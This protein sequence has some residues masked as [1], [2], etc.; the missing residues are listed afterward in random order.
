MINFSFF[1]HLK[2]KKITA[3]AG[4]R[5]RKSLVVVVHKMLQREI[6]DGEISLGET[7]SCFVMHFW[8]DQCYYQSLKTDP[9]A[10]R[11]AVMSLAPDS[12]FSRYFADVCSAV[13]TP[14]VGLWSSFLF[15]LNPSSFPLCCVVLL[16]FG[17]R[18]EFAK[19]G[20]VSRSLCAFGMN[21][22]TC[23]LTGRL[24]PN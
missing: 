23:T 7:A 12:S 21:K 18:D 20:H 8:F 3:D 10:A 6:V 15:L 2:K 24:R 22:L 16:L 4:E 14:P 19:S 1:L 9:S 5:R 17:R 11:I 13:G